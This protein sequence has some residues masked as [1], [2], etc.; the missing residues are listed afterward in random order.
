MN[1]LGKT[2]LF[3][4]LA[5]TFVACNEGQNSVV[6]STTSAGEVTTVVPTTAAPKVFMKYFYVNA[7]TGEKSG[8]MLVQA[9]LASD[10]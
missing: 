7:A 10:I 1:K 4:A 8:E 6:S 3:V 5:L 9:T 2:L